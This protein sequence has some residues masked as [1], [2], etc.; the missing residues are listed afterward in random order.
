MTLS[1]EY[2]HTETSFI[3]NPFDIGSVWY[4]IFERPDVMN[5]VNE[6]A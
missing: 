4:S 1:N 2:Y 6:S 5:F 3:S